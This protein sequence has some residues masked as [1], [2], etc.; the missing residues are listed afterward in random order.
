MTTA[1]ERGSAHTPVLLACIVLICIFAIGWKVSQNQPTDDTSQS[2]PLPVATDAGSQ[3]DNKQLA[4]W[5]VDG[6]PGSTWRYTGGT[7]PRCPQPI[8]AKSPSDMSRATDIGLPGQYR[9][10]HYKAHGGVRFDGSEA[11]DITVQLPLDATL[12]GLKRYFEADELQYL[13]EF[14]HPCGIRIRFDHVAVS[15]PQFQAIAETTPAPTADTRSVPT[16]ELF[17]QKFTAGTQVASA[18]GM[19]KANN[20]GYDFGVYDIRQP[21]AVSRNSTWADLHR[22]ESSYAYYGVCWIPMLPSAQAKQ[23]RSL[24]GSNPT[25]T[26]ISDYCTDA[27]GGGTL[28]Y[29]SGRP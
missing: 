22:D 6:G 27:P 20:I 1:A 7:P 13:L 3:P 17:G 10:T 12:V 28:Q 16:P 2:R 15:T 23:L 29:N 26:Y 5:T 11:T 19:P 18:V 4:G 14:E 24:Y 8:L 21:N 9:G 25:N